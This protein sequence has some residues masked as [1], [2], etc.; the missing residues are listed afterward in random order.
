ML[1]SAMMTDLGE[2]A[3]WHL[4]NRINPEAPAQEDKLL[5]ARLL[6]RL[7]EMHEQEDQAISQDL[8]NIEQSTSK[9][10]QSLKGEE[11]I[12]LPINHGTIKHSPSVSATS[13]ARRIKAW[14]HLFQADS[15]KKPWIIAADT[16]TYEFIA[17]HTSKALTDHPEKLFSLPV[18]DALFKD[19]NDN[20]Y[21][22]KRAHFFKSLKTRESLREILWQSAQKGTL[23]GNAPLEQN[24]ANWSKEME[25][26][27]N[28]QTPGA[29]LNFFLLPLPLH[30]LFSK[31][32]QFNSP[33][34]NDM[35]LPR[36]SI[37]VTITSPQ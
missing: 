6:L 26:V 19:I 12:S 27:G 13:I 20:E 30:A 1:S 16:D 4:I 25:T 23:T 33:Q 35:D 36:Y 34:A 37:I 14:A 2:S 28:G 10:L 11:E 17:E 24:I 22:Q 31:I 15:N 5:Q 7:I 29:F 21:M 32:T 8:V 18:A 3:V 9:L